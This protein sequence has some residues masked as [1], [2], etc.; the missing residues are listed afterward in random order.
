MAPAGRPCLAGSDN[1]QRSPK[2]GSAPFHLRPPQVPIAAHID[3]D[4]RVVL[5]WGLA[6]TLE[7]PH[8]N[9]DFGDAAVVPELQIAAAGH[10]FRPL[11]LAGSLDSL[12]SPV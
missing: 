5:R 8:P 6:D 2:L 12:P 10:R 3:V 11:W 1:G 7:F 4:V 9:A